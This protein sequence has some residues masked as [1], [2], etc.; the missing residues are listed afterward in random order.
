LVL[1]P[2]EEALSLSIETHLTKSQIRSQA[3]MKNC[4]L[5]PSYN[6]G[7]TAKKEN[8]PSKG[9]ILNRNLY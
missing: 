5:Y 1:Y 9:K 6:E 3:K 4:N 7:K 2:P 8:Y